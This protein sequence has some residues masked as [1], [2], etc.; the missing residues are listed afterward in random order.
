MKCMSTF[1]RETLYIALIM[2]LWEFRYK[3]G[4]IMSHVELLK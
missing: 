1:K 2:D 3:N 4:H